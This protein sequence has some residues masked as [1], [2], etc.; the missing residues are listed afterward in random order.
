M[1]TDK[2][3]QLLEAIVRETEKG[4]LVWEMQD[5]TQEI[6]FG[7]IDE[8]PKVSWCTRRNKEEIRLTRLIR[9]PQIDGGGHYV[10]GWHITVAGHELSG[11]LREKR[12]GWLRR[13]LPY[14]SYCPAERLHNYLYEQWCANSRNSAQASRATAIDRALGGL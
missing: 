11:P 6:D 14:R 7:G 1:L 13:I 10:V 12:T 5:E 4:T 2:E 8:N 9:V 3:R